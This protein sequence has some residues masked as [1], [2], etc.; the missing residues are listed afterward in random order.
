MT[1]PAVLILTVRPIDRDSSA[2]PIAHKPRLYRHYDTGNA[3]RA[4]R[5]GPEG[6]C[7]QIRME[8]QAVNAWLSFEEAKELAVRSVTE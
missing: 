3:V 6:V 5:Q 8:K 1:N 7:V 2:M 4:F